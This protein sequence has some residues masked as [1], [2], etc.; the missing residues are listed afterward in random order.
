MADIRKQVELILSAKD[1]ASAKLRTVSDRFDTLKR[2]AGQLMDVLG[3]LAG[4][5]ALREIVDAKT[6]WE[7]YNN[8]LKTVTGSQEAANR[9]LEFVKQL[10]GKLGLDLQSS[11]DAYTQLAA[12]AK[13]T[14]LSLEQVHKIFAAVSAASSV[15]GLS[16]DQTSGAFAAM[17][18]MLSK[19]KVSAEE[20]RGQLG[21]RLPGAFSLFAK[22]MGVST[23]ELDQMLQKGEV[24]A[25]DT[26]PAFADAL[27]AAYGP[28]MAD[29][30]S[31]TQAAINRFNSEFFNLKVKLADSGV[32]DL[33]A[34]ALKSVTEAI[35]DPTLP[36][37]L[38]NLKNALTVT[39]DAGSS[40]SVVFDGLLKVFE[41]FSIGLQTVMIPIKLAG[42]VIGATAAAV[43]AAAE[44]DFKG[45][46]DALTDPTPANNFNKAIDDLVVSTER[47]WDTTK[48]V[49]TAT[50]KEGKAAA[51][52]ALQIKKQGDETGKAAGASAKSADASDKDAKAKEK[53]AEAARK[54]AEKAAELKV[55]LEKIASNERI[56]TLEITAN[57]NLE[58][59]KSNTERAKSIIASID[60][61]ISSTGDLLGNLFGS[62][63]DAG[64]F[65]DKWAIEEQIKEENRRRDEALE[66]QKELT[67]TEIALNKEKLKRLKSG[68]AIIKISGDG[69]APDLEAFMWKVLER[70]Q[71]R[72]NEEQAEFL[73]GV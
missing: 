57:F 29:A 48:K 59:L 2:A 23:S 70:I 10:A 69:L 62:L 47:F 19:G 31:S 60:N 66:Q 35:S 28:G 9:E 44:G 1:G 11:I 37:A 67:E 27:L 55:E 8:A 56:K 42:D 4:A 6:S 38:E 61:T 53:Q 58:K 54:A 30:A 43:A 32:V 15:L 5:L 3:P 13:N 12:S 50:E 65:S 20:L 40:M 72:V 63:K 14:G 22:S 16:T 41:A 21:E 45:A 33:F 68:D 17:S 39:N 26:L 64:D 52:A 25:K 51:D 73:I 36:H 18:Q 34:E 49:E 71:L 46:W 7:G 24:A